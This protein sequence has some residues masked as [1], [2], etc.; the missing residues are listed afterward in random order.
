ML[1]LL[2]ERASGSEPGF[3]TKYVRWAI[4]FD[5]KRGVGGIVELGQPEQKKNRGREFSK[6][7]DLTQPELVSGSSPRSHF[8]VEAASVVAEYKLPQNDRKTPLKHKF[9]VSMLTEAGK[10]TPQLRVIAQ[11]MRDEKVL[12]EIRQAMADSKVKPGDKV[13]FRLDG[14][15]PLERDYWHEWWRSYRPSLTGAEEK[16]IKHGRFRCFVTGDL[17]TPAA[18][19]PKV[20]GLAAVGGLATGDVLIGFDKEAYSSYGLEQS[21]NAA[22]SEEAAKAYT[23][24]LNKLIRDSS[25][26]LGKAIVV[27]WFK[28]KVEDVDDP[29]AFLTEASEVVELN[30]QE[31]ARRLLR[32]LETGERPDLAG[33]RYYILTISGAGGRVM[34][35]DW[36]EGEFVEL[37][38]NIN[39][40]FDDLQM[41]WHDGARI[42][43]PPRFIPLL[44]ALAR[45]LNE[46]ATPLVSKLWR[47]AVQGEEI[48]YQVLSESVRRGK[49][50]ILQND[51]PNVN[52]MALIRAY[53]LRKYRK[54]GNKLAEKLTPK[55]NKDFPHVAYHCGRLMAVLAQLQRAALGDVGA[56]VVQRYY[57]AASTTPALVLGRLTTNSQHHLNK[58]EAGLARW[59]ESKISEIWSYIREPLPR[60]LTLEEQ[61]LF[62]LGYYHEL[63]SFRAGKSENESKE[64]EK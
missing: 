46:L 45:D 2:A 52:G 49:V 54:E 16:S 25:S 57:A 33:N 44:Q 39:R 38:R 30:A 62:A 40:W 56:G 19:H 17:T 24:S 28:E 22:V 27:H 23:D 5:S 61:S 60:T 11:F 59:Y 48:P 64:K 10:H 42:A 51:E 47:V 29:V 31:R 1:E 20:R 55:L 36:L 32:S 12:Q 8:L 21:A 35:R 15:F 41:V 58:L 37:V 7:P 34:V 3:S 14:E 18:T 9:F 6:C 63:A 26:K 4:V 53:H 50:E 13:T 43:L